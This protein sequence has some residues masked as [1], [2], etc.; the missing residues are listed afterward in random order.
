MSDSKRGV[1]SIGDD[2]NRTNAMDYI[3]IQTTGNAQDFG[4]L[5]APRDDGASSSDSHGGIS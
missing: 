2:G 5:T 1:I 4:D 3:T